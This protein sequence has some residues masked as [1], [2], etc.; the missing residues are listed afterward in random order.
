MARL[1]SLSSVLPQAMQ[2]S[3]QYAASD[4]ML[5]QIRRRRMEREEQD[6]KN[7]STQMDNEYKRSQIGATKSQQL[8]AGNLAQIEANAPQVIMDQGGKVFS[9]TTTAWATYMMNSG[10]PEAIDKV[11]KFFS[12][13]PN[14]QSNLPAGD[15]STVGTRA[16]EASTQNALA[17]AGQHHETAKLLASQGKPVPTPGQTTQ[18][19]VRSS[20]AYLESKESESG[21]GLQ[22]QFP[23]V[24]DKGA[25]VDPFRHADLAKDF[26][27]QARRQGMHNYNT[28]HAEED[29]YQFLKHKKSPPWINNQS[30]QISVNPNTGEVAT[31]A[32][33]PTINLMNRP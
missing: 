25:S 21:Y 10:H 8:A 11:Q 2:A 13:M 33:V 6:R 5:D 19:D 15:R 12:G 28:V 7:S 9:Q 3:S 23:F 26:F 14:Y 29:A 18:F 31:P 20:E 24:E 32:T 22:S 17:S 30:P 16:T 27:N 4:P 1:S